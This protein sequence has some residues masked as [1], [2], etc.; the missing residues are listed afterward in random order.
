[1]STLPVSDHVAVTILVTANPP[2]VPSFSGGLI[3]G[4]SARLALGQRV[5]AVTR[6]TYASY[7][8]ASDPEYTA[9]A[10]FFSQSPAPATA[11]AARWFTAAAAGYL[12]GGVHEALTPL[13][14]ITAGAF[15]VVVDATTINVTSLDLSGA[16]TLA[17]VATL[18]Q[19]KLHAGLAGTTCTYDATAAKF[20]VTSPTTGVSSQVGFATVTA[21]DTT[22]AGALGL[23]HAAGASRTVG[24]AL[25]TLTAALDAI[26]LFSSAWYAFATVSDCSF[27]N[28]KLAADWAEANAR[29]YFVTTNLPSA[30][31]APVAASGD[32]A[33]IAQ[34]A[35]AKNYK[36]TFTMF[37]TD[38]LDAAVSAM[39]RINAVDYTQPNSVITL[40]FKQLP[41]VAAEALTET[42]KQA[43]DLNH[44]NYYATF[45]TFD[46]LGEGWMADGTFTDQVIGLDW[47]TAQAQTDVFAALATATTKI[48]Q[49]DPG[50]FRIQKALEGSLRQARSNGLVAPGTWPAT[51]AGLGEV[52]PGEFLEEGFYVYAQPVALQSSTARGLRAAPAISAIACGAGAL[53]SVAITI[54]F[55]P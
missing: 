52:D 37:S 32:A 50:V 31:A 13:K 43:L 30:Y 6:D 35:N 48:P 21:G 15:D 41:G 19:T 33:D 27:A 9:L 29:P 10:K 5:V 1:M 2:S 18:V 4:T 53:H 25:E 54:N 24:I 8:S 14:T 7:Y 45:G 40:K 20:V 12:T 44:C 36:R 39:A 22:T 16:A 49:T 28:H 46:M 47:L 26:K 34:Y 42:Q 55:Q 17:A 3:V 51:N 38:T 23:S 11:Y